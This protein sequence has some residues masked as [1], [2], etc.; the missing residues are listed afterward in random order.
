MSVKEE[1]F[2]FTMASAIADLDRS[3][4]DI[5]HIEDSWILT[6]ARMFTNG[7]PYFAFHVHPGLA[8]NY[9]LLNSIKP[10]KSCTHTMPDSVWFLFKLMKE[11]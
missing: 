5:V 8:G 3:G 6:K 10:Y 1:N 7:Y 9:G 11:V 4:W 2:R